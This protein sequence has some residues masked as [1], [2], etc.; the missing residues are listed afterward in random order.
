MALVAKPFGLAPV[1]T[2]DANNF[3]QAGTRYY[4][5]SGDGSA[6]YIGDT[7]ISAAGADANGVPQIAKA[8]GTSTVRG[9]IIG[10][11]HDV[12]PLLHHGVTQLS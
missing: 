5:P 8:I 2:A 3:N 4:I 1:R 10:V 6:Y 12:T 7:V 9:V 11:H